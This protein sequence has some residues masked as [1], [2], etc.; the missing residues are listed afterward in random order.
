VRRDKT[1]KNCFMRQVRWAD[2]EGD[3][4][5]ILRETCGRVLKVHGTEETER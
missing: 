3:V 2:L 5:F 4:G 1:L